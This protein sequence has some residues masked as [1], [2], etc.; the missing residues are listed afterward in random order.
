MLV[1]SMCDVA[2]QPDADGDASNKQHIGQKQSTEKLRTRLL[3]LFGRL[4]SKVRLCFYRLVLQLA[5]LCV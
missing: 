2:P 1:G 4:T 5:L 3:E